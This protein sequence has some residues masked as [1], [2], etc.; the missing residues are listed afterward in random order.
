MNILNLSP[1]KEQYD[2]DNFQEISCE[3][4]MHYKPI[5]RMSPPLPIDCNE[6]LGKQSSFGFP[7]LRAQPSV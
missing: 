6:S 7:K 1:H 3:N 4:V 2:K 5:P